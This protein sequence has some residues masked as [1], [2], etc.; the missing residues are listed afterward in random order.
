MSQLL[1][2]GKDVAAEE[3]TMATELDRRQDAP[4]G[5]ILN[6]RFAHQEQHCDLLGG[7]QLR[8]VGIGVHSGAHLVRAA[9][10]ARELPWVRDTGPPILP[11]AGRRPLDRGLQPS[12]RP[13]ASEPATP[14]SP[15]RSARRAVPTTTRSSKASSPRSSRSCDRRS[16]TT[17]LELISEAFELIEGLL[18]RHPPLD[19]VT[20]TRQSHQHR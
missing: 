13:S 3:A 16:G 17:R 4:T 15:S 1:D 11:P 6:G 10:D 12:A 20:S 2:G 8:K 9:G 19:P 18:Q 5:V 7:H 14:T